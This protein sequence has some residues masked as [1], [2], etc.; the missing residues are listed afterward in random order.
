MYQA[1]AERI[2]FVAGEVLERQIGEVIAVWKRSFYLRMDDLR[3]DGGLVCVGDETIGDGPLNVVVTTPTPVDWRMHATLGQVAAVDH[4]RLVLDRRAV[5][6]LDGATTWTPLPIPAWSK[7]SVFR[8]LAHLDRI[9]DARQPPRDGLGCYVWACARLLQSPDPV[10]AAASLP[11]SALTQWLQSEHSVSRPAPKQIQELLGLGPGLTPSGDDLLSA[12]LVTL[13]AIGSE[14]FANRL[15]S[16]LK[17]HLDRTNEI[18]A[19]HLLSAARGTGGARLHSLLNAVLSGSA[20][21]ITTAVAALAADE[22]TS[23]WDGLAG[24]AITLH[25][26]FGAR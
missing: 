1:R 14:K 17:D 13:H 3:K 6:E 4:G 8:G 26:I 18:S 23:N 21:D 12:V 11:I 2:G 16:A 25:A 22:H 10:V 5:I 19:A 9:C 15:W 20:A 24:A 7:Q